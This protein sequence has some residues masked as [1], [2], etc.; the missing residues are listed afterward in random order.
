M[1]CSSASTTV[2]TMTKDPTLMAP[3]SSR[4]MAMAS[5]P[6]MN[7]ARRA[8]FVTNTHSDHHHSRR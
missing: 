2:I 7:E 3:P 8:P 5:M 4:R 6:R 1:R